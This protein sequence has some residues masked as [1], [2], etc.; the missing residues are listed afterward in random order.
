MEVDNYV[1]YY[2]LHYQDRLSW[3]KYITDLSEIDKILKIQIPFMP[4]LNGGIY[5][6]NNIF[7]KFT[8]PMPDQAGFSIITISTASSEQGE[9]LLV[10]E[11]SIKGKKVEALNRKEWFLKARDMQLQLFD[12]LFHAEILQSWV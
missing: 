11:C 3:Q 5:A 1:K 4:N 2:E 12:Q 6:P 10:V 7:S 9:Q 8:I